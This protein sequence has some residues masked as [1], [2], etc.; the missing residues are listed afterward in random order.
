[1]SNQNSYEKRANDNQKDIQWQ[2]S[3]CANMDDSSEDEHNE[4]SSVHK[5]VEGNHSQTYDC[6][7]TFASLP[8]DEE[9]AKPS[10]FVSLSQQKTTGGRSVSRYGQNLRYNRG[11]FR[12]VRGHRYKQDR[13]S[14]SGNLSKSQNYAF[15]LRREANSSVLN[16]KLAC[17]S[18]NGP[19][20]CE[21]DVEHLS[22]SVTVSNMGT[23]ND[24]C[25]GSVCDSMANLSLNDPSDKLL[26]WRKAKEEYMSISQTVSPSE[27]KMDYRKQIDKLSNDCTKRNLAKIDKILKLISQ[28]KQYSDVFELHYKNL[29]LQ[30]DNFDAYISSMKNKCTGIQDNNVDDI[31]R[32][33][34]SI[35]KKIRNE[36]NLFERTLPAYAYKSDII[37]ALTNHQIVFVSADCSYFFNI[38]TPIIV[39][40]E[41]SDYYA[42][43]C[44][45]NNM[46]CMWVKSDIENIAKNYVENALNVVCINEEKM[47]DYLKDSLISDKNCFIVNLPLKRSITCDFLLASISDI[48]LKQKE[49]KLILLLS[50]F[51]CLEKYEKYFLNFKIFLLKVPKLLLPVQT[52]WKKEPLS[53]SKNYIEDV[54]CTALSIHILND[55][56]DVL[57][58]MPSQADAM[59]AIV[60]LIRKI[61]DLNYKD[62]DCMVLHENISNIL[63]FRQ[64]SKNEKRKILFTTSCAEIIPIPSVRYVI[65][66]GLT[67]DFI[68]DS[69][70]NLDV[71]TTIFNSR[72]KSRLR[73]SL[74]GVYASGIIYRIFNKDNFCVDMPS[75]ELPYMLT[76][77][78]FNTLIKIFHHEP[79][80]NLS[81]Q[82]VEPLNDT[83]KYNAVINLKN[84]NA[85]KS[86]KEKLKLT[87]LGKTIVKL[88]FTARYSKLILQ[89]MQWGF[90][91]EAILLVA[92]FL[93]DSYLFKFTKDEEYQQ[94]IDASKFELIQQD[95]DALSFLHIYKCWAEHDYSVAW[96]DQFH[97]HY[98]FLDKVKIKAGDLCQTV[99]ECLNENI[100]QEF[101]NTEYSSIIEMLFQCF[102]DNLCVFSGHYRCGY[103][104][105]SSRQTAFVHPSSIICNKENY[106]QLIVFDRVVNT[107]RYFLHGITAVPKNL[108][109]SS[110]AEKTLKYD[111]SDI[112]ERTLVL[113]TIEPI[114]ERIIKQV[115]LGTEGK[116]LLE[117]EAGLK[118]ELKSDFLVIDPCPEKGCVNVY[119]L[120]PYV[121][122]AVNKVNEILK[123][124]VNDVIKAEKAFTVE[125][126]KGEITV[127]LEVNCVK[128]AKVTSVKL[129]NKSQESSPVKSSNGLNSKDVNSSI[130]FS[131]NL[132]WIRRA[133]N[134]RCFVKFAPESFMQ[135]RKLAMRRI[136]ILDSDVYV[137]VSNREDAELF[138]TEL[139]PETRENDVSEALNNYLPG[140]MISKIEIKF[141]Q[142][143]ETTSKDI[144]ELKIEIQENCEEY[145]RLEDFDIIIPKPKNTATIMTAFINVFGSEDLTVAAKKLSNTLI[146]NFKANAI[147]VYRSVMKVN[148]N[149]YKALEARFIEGIDKLKCELSKVNPDKDLFRFEA[150]HIVVSNSVILKLLSNDMKI[151]KHLQKTINELLEGEVLNKNNVCD[152]HKLFCHGGH[153]WLR[154]LAQN[155]KVYI[156]EEYNLKTIRVY[157]SRVSCFKVKESICKFL[158]NTEYEAV[159]T[160]ILSTDKNNRV[161]LKSLIKTYGV[162]LESFVDRCGLRSAELNIRTCHLL[163]HGCRVSINE[164]C[165]FFSY[166]Y[167]RC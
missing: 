153:M 140:I 35:V 7:E 19:P 87:Q 62:V 165:L 117:I 79:E 13:H 58:F 105:L 112:F 97:V 103:Q 95:S 119:A 116:K 4:T 72:A 5:R 40:S 137:E 21:Q 145:A 159:E 99:S 48:L 32:K 1:M 162:N 24:R 29:R 142:P 12:R 75:H 132:T 158:A 127:P 128:G 66:C 8:S 86:D 154:I 14:F 54:V 148:Y 74:V 80:K 160:I 56:G 55:G 65:D 46:A 96:C 134:G 101:C 90:A 34:D 47:L 91:Y 78:P 83:V 107:S 110:I 31:I 6:Q 10:R 94:V 93:S 82:F 135:A 26:R 73:K 76:L 115:L 33:S 60:M 16:E 39:S 144:E 63:E 77:N 37:S 106:P 130:K 69:D 147:P 49:S 113:R 11:N 59:T 92:Y 167:Y 157:G 71:L 133:C 44:E 28:E 100:L 120:E 45:S 89:G 149:A 41:L 163:L 136:E 9:P 15:N 102:A 125:M 2:S 166:S 18:N 3:F 61:S 161:L 150:D 123:N 146:R 139:P 38:V 23:E 122:A 143:F 22:H 108:V 50:L 51:D 67:R 109:L 138:L 156:V 52:V 64:Q 42:V 85:I 81:L 164:V 30:Q 126:K 27:L 151:M 141:I 68:F 104:I 155:K 98:T 118:K 131:I 88:P 53:V 114:G 17:I 84:F 111:Y 152:I 36:C 124:N 70:K 43:A 25:D 129:K 121:K 57:A 20:F